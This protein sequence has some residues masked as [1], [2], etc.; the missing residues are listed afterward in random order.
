MRS[1]QVVIERLA[2]ATV[3]GSIPAPSDT[4]ES[5]GRQMSSV[6]EHTIKEKTKKIML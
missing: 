2:V 1:S 5:E 6:E 3:L 4:G